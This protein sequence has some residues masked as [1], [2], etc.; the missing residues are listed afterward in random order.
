MSRFF[1]DKR[2]YMLLSI[3]NDVLARDESRKH[4]R[5]TI[6]PY[7]HPHGIKEMAESR[8]LRIAHAVVHL[9]EY[10]EAEG[11]DDRLNALRSIRD[12]LVETAEG[13]MPKNTARVLM[14]I[15][16][17]LV[18]AHGNQELQLKFAHD[19]RSSTT[20]KPRIIRK[21]MKKYHLLEMP[22]EWNQ[23]TFDD[24]VHDA[25]TKGR[26]SSS[27]LIMDAWIKG[28][29][30]LKVVYYNHLE[31]KFAMELLE[32]AK[33]MG[34]DIQIGIEFNARFRDRYI[35]MI[36]TPRGFADTQDFLIFLEEDPVRSLMAEGR[37][38]S[39]YQGRHVISIL[40]KFNE[41]HR[42][43]IETRYGFKPD[44]LDEET[45]RTFVG[46]GQ[47]SLF[48]LAKFAHMSMLPAMDSYTDELRKFYRNAEGEER[49][50]I[51]DKVSA[52][53]Q[54]DHE[55]ILDDFLVPEKNP[56]IA[57]PDIPVDNNDIPFLLTLTPL[58]LAD[59]V[60]RL[61]S[62]YRITLNLSNLKVEDV[63]EILY[64]CEGYITCLE[65]FNLKDYTMG[66]TG[67][68]PEINELQNAINQGNVIELKRLIRGIIDRIGKSDYPDR[69]NR[70]ARL[71]DI[72]HDISLL[73]DYY[74]R[75]PLKS[76]IG[77]D[78]T[79][80]SPRFHGMGLAV[81]ETLP[82]K[83]QKEINR[84]PDM[85]YEIIPGKISIFRRKIYI[86][87]AISGTGFADN[88]YRLIRQIPFLREF[89]FRQKVDWLTQGFS[90][91][92]K[93]DIATLGGI[94]RKFTNGLSLRVSPLKKE[95]GTVSWK[96]LN[97]GF[98]NFLK[99][100]IGFVPAFLTFLLT[101]DWW[102][103]VYF[104][105]VI[106]F[107]ITGLR[108]ILQSVLG[109]GGLRRSR[110]IRW[111]DFIRWERISD[112]LFYTGFSVPLLDYLVKTVLLNRL[113]GINTTSDPVM[114]Y[115]VMAIINGIYLASH[116]AFRGFPT[117]V[118]TGNF[119]RSVISI[120]VA[121]LFNGTVSLILSV[122]GITGTE[123]VLQ[124][125]AAIISKAASDS[126]AGIIEGIADRYQN[127]H[128]R[129]HDYNKKMTQL[130]YIYSMLE[131]RFPEYQVMK[132]LEEP[133]RFEQIR[134]EEVSAL[135][136]ILIINA[137]DLLYFWMYQPRARST[138]KIKL[139]R[140]SDE[141]RRIF[142]TFQNVLLLE[143]EVTLL[144]AD[145]LVGKNFSK[146]L[147]FYL[148]NFKAYLESMR[149]LAN[150]L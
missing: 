114:L 50:V 52:M 124:K 66:L 137:L 132:L 27:Y 49:S 10:L 40:R 112:S 61:R 97:T 133:E 6:Y 77:S 141:E 120:P 38:V 34:I 125:W 134:S 102:F 98:K 2:D 94:Q 118:V 24:H 123:H 33:I 17:E 109:G 119:F 58:E 8:G 115:T 110:L 111:N 127:M 56:D 101:K 146:A 138:L 11:V 23:V 55:K 76:R 145:G 51:E 144:F 78:S 64:D 39:E 22:E 126:V 82:L 107:G 45:F 30:R 148:S 121:I 139:K 79:G 91:D 42:F 84:H 74:K 71:D 131:I 129:W 25:N 20:G 13:S 113:W 26:K 4:T 43:E 15:M 149:R 54:L 37:K 95:R 150:T 65:I 63:I 105:A 96:Y 1:F 21:Q 122:A 29:R 59:R 140:I 81:V 116:N 44:P 18:R 14:Q 100:F 9:L 70:V 7:L 80:R 12:E 130:H 57:D 108:N 28:I 106:W 60:R 89:G 85:S 32:A 83:A 47:I 143:R 87:H 3:V 142:I 93:G 88:F 86:P 5:K 90:I 104:G 117:G 62:S 128:M 53:N 147:S 41:K 31:A 103:L 67:H 46:T 135:Q 72:L 99:V 69:Q 73:K 92:G 36:W 35:Q 136:K 16:K 75:I 48:H 68:I 19:F